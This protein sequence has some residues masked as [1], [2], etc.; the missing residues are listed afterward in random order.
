M[1]IDSDLRRRELSA[2]AQLSAG[3]PTPG[4]K[5]VLREAGAAWPTRLPRA[6]SR[7]I[8][9]C[10]YSNELPPEPVLSDSVGRY[11]VL[12]DFTS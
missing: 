1:R 3:S 11:A 9:V 5:R 12:R 2:S 6:C 10:V 8:G 4:P 7:G